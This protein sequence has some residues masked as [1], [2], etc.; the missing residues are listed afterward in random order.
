MAMPFLASQKKVRIKLESMIGMGRDMQLLPFLRYYDAYTY[1]RGVIA[2]AHYQTQA[3]R[4]QG[5]VSPV[6]VDTHLLEIIV[7]IQ[8]SLLKVI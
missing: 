6:K 7:T 8:G 1:V 4:R 3:S 5:R 2:E